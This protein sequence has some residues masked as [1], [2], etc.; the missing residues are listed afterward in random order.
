[1]KRTLNTIYHSIGYL[2]ICLGFVICIAAGGTS[3]C[4]AD[5]AFVARVGLCGLASLLCGV[6]LAWWRV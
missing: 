2:L 6:F 4:G 5:M 1:M 3:D